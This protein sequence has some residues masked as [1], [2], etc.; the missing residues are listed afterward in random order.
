MVCQKGPLT[1]F[2]VVAFGPLNFVIFGFNR[3]ATLIKLQGHTKWQSQ[4]IELEPRVPL[5]IGFQV[6]S[7]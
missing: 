4:I 3:F 7:L 6:K 2:T 1:S 5:K